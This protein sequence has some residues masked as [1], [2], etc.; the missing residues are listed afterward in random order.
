M[1]DI[2]AQLGHSGHRPRI[3]AF[4]DSPPTLLEPTGAHQCQRSNTSS[5]QNPGPI[6]I[7]RPGL[8]LGGFLAMVSRSTCSTE[9]EDR[10]PISPRERHV[11]SRASGGRPRLAGIA[12]MIFGPPGWLTQAPTSVVLRPCNPRNDVTSSAMYCSTTV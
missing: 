12:S 6:A 5:E 10:L 9:A 3:A 2:A 1:N 8:P 4:A 7:I 11:S